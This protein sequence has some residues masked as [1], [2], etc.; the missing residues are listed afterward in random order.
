MATNA[1]EVVYRCLLDENWLGRMDGHDELIVSETAAA[2]ME[3]A[4]SM[5]H[6]PF[7]RKTRPTLR[8]G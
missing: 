6:H 2:L 5:A 7:M 8:R 1:R 4:E 3:L